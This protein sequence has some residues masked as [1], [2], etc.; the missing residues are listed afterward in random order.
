LLL[1][2][3]LEYDDNL[4]IGFLGSFRLLAD[5]KWTWPGNHTT[6]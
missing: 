1:L 6:I 2:V 4:K 5:L 3:K